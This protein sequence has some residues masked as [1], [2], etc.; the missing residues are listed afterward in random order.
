MNKLALGA[1]ALLLAGGCA[2]VEKSSGD[3][4]DVSDV[5]HEEVLP[6]SDEA[7]FDLS[8]HILARVS[9]L[10]GGGVPSV[11]NECRFRLAESVAG[12]MAVIDSYGGDPSLGNE[13][14]DYAAENIDFVCGE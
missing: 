12:C 9:D 7:C 6:C 5:R 14:I 10:T 13:C 1:L 3:A 4:P 2:E 11:T 8:E